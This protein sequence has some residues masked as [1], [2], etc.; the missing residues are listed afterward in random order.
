MEADKKIK[1]YLFKKD[2]YIFYNRGNK[3]NSFLVSKNLRDKISFFENKS[4]K[5]KDNFNKFLFSI[6]K[7]SLPRIFL[8]DFSK[9]KS[10][11]NNL[12]WPKKPNYI[13]TSYGNENDDLFNSYVMQAKKNN[14]KTKLCILQHGYGCIFSNE[15][16]IVYY[17]NKKIS[18]IF[19]TWVTTVVVKIFF[20]QNL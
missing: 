6:L 12:N 17:L 2:K 15:D 16:F 8:E 13:L 9:L 20:I 19:L 10:I 18:D 7:L 14:T 3:N 11:S 4:F 1:L 5:N